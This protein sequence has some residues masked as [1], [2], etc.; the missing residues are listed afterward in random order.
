MERLTSPPKLALN[1][2]Q[3]HL[4]ELIEI[5]VSMM[6]NGV[7]NLHDHKKCPEIRAASSEGDIFEK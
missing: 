3:V 1:H 6:N 4:F 2:L 5:I 7:G